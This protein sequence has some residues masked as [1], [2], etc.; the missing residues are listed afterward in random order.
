MSAP[1]GTI[2]EATGLVVERG[3]RRIVDAVDCA[4]VPGRLTILLG[5]NGAGKSTL[6]KVLSGDL[7]P[8]A[9]TVALEGRALGRWERRALACRRAVLPQASSLHFPFR[10]EEV[11]AMGRSPH[12]GR[13]SLAEDRRVCEEALRRVELLEARERRYPTL[14]GGEQQRVQFAR[15]LAQLAGP[16]ESGPQVLFLDEPTSSLDLRH[17]QHLLG[18][19][20]ELADGGCAVL[21][22]LHDLNLA[23]AYADDVWLLR[24]GA[25]VAAGAAETVLEP[26]TIEAVFGVAVRA[27]REEGA[28]R[29]LLALAAGGRVS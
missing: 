1:G 9:G 21:A 8:E 11:V 2:L 12:Y 13:C 5:P 29:P 14:S 4:L 27:W 17:Q 23:M 19:A 20:R 10:V 25:L 16:G 28:A 3:G 7:V 26:A 24:D 6:L 15:V 18:H 22:I